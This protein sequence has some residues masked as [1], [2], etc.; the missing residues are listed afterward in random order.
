MTEI[1]TTAVSTGTVPRQTLYGRLVTVMAAPAGDDLTS[2][3]VAELRLD[4]GG[5]SGDRHFGFTRKAGAREPWYP[6]GTVIRS[7]REL[8]IVSREELGEVARRM[9]LAEL[10][11]EWIGANLVLEGIPRL[12]RLPTGTRIFFAGDASAVVEAINGPC[13]DAGRSIARHAGDR[14]E[15]E[16]LFSKV[17]LGLRGIVAS[18]ERAGT[19][20]PGTDLTV[21]V[22]EQCLYC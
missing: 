5:V 22:P 9:D 16:L 12:S 21:R 10:P 7:G 1:S 8:S 4:H 11:P 13:R 3:P 14:K 20:R 17:A 18:V 2:A 15:L 6:R 19:I